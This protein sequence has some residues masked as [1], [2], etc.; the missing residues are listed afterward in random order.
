DSGGS[1][2]AFAGPAH[3][4]SADTRSKRTEMQA[5][6][7]ETRTGGRAIFLPPAKQQNFSE[8]IAFRR[9]SSIG[10]HLRLPELRKSTN[11]NTDRGARKRCKGRHAGG[12]TQNVRTISSTLGI[13]CC[14]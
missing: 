8:N 11:S 12:L 1:A 10:V 13:V 4:M 7:G 9:A 3:A 14:I 6:W 2:G 5:R